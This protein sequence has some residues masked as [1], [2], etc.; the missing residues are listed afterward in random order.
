MLGTSKDFFVD[1][2]ASAKLSIGSLLQQMY[3]S[4]PSGLVRLARVYIFHDGGISKEPIK[5]SYAIPKALS[6]DLYCDRANHEHNIHLSTVRRS[7]VLRLCT[8]TQ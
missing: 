1:G 3:Q 8:A 5:F 6:M 4:G 7:V 2:N